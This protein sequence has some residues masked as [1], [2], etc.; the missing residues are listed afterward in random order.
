[1]GNTYNFEYRIAHELVK[2]LNSHSFMFFLRF[3]CLLIDFNH[4]LTH[5]TDAGLAHK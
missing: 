3:A 1:M 4:S 2:E 5:V